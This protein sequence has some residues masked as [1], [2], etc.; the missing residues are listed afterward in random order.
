MATKAATTAV[1]ISIQVEKE[2]DKIEMDS[3][4]MFVQ[5]PRARLPHVLINIGCEGKQQVRVPAGSVDRIPFTRA[6]AYARH[7]H[8]DEN[9]SKVEPEREPGL[10]QPGEVSRDALLER[11]RELK[12]QKEGLQG[13]IQKTRSSTKRQIEAT[14]KHITKEIERIRSTMKEFKAIFR[15]RFRALWESLQSTNR[16]R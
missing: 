11:C 10:L 5:H 16:V 7:T 8:E 3:V 4:R 1:A 13:E 9:W 2:E 12:R 6:L 14:T 15:A